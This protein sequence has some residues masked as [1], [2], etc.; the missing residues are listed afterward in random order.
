MWLMSLSSGHM[1]K[2][3]RLISDLVTRQHLQVGTTLVDPIWVRIEHLSIV[4]QSLCRGLRGVLW[5]AV[6]GPGHDHGVCN[7]HIEGYQQSAS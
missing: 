5:V 2:A 6:C 3:S 4:A 7:G 1:P